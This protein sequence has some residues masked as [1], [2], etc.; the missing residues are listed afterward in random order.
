MNIK[1]AE[2]LSGVSRQNIRFYEREGLL[3]SDRN[4]VNDYREYNDSHIVTLKQIRILRMLD[5]PIEQIKAIQSGNIPLKDAVQIQKQKLETQ[6]ENLTA[7][8]HYC[9]S[10]AA[11]ESLAD[12]DVDE[13]LCRMQTEESQQP[14]FRKWLEDYRKV[15]LSEQEKVFTFVPDEAVT[16]SREFTNALLAYADKQNLDLTVT[17]EGMY[18]EFTIDGV[19]YT[20]ERFYTSVSRVPVATIRCSVKYPEDFEP[21]IQKGQKRWMKLLHFGLPAVPFLLLMF[22]VFRSAGLQASWMEW[23]A[24]AG[25]VVLVF[26]QLYRN[27]LLHYNENGK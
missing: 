26:V 24:L 25:L 5:M 21:D 17:R 20:A 27:Y 10:L 6:V 8:M 19:E 18:P 14:L 15:I 16:S 1:D 3:V 11:R 2:Q 23:F 4:P 22:F 12:L 9:D 7:A 13:F